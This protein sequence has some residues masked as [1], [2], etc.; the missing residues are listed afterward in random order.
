MTDSRMNRREPRVVRGLLRVAWYELRSNL[1]PPS[2]RRRLYRIGAAALGVA[3]WFGIFSA[4]RGGVSLLMKELP[5]VEGA[6]PQTVELL[7]AV[8]LFTLAYSG[9]VVTL[10]RVYL[11]DSLRLVGALPAEAGTLFWSYWVQVVAAAG[12]MPLAFGTA[13]LSGIGAALGVPAFWYL[14]LA[15]GFSLFVV[16][17]V[18]VSLLGTT[19]IATLLP[20]SR[21]RDMLLVMSLIGLVGLFVAIRSLRPERL[22]DQSGAKKLAEALVEL[23]APGAGWLP[24]S[25]LADSLTPVFSGGAVNLKALAVL[26][27]MTAVLVALS[28]FVFAAAFPIA[29]SQALSA[30]GQWLRGESWVSK[31][32]WVVTSPLPRSVAALTRKDILH[33]GRDAT[34]WSQLLLIVGLAVIYLFNMSALPLEDARQIGTSKAVLADWIAVINLMPA[35][36]VLAAVALRFVYAA[37]SLEGRAAWISLSAPSGVG[38]LV[39]AKIAVGFPILASLGVVLVTGTNAILGTSAGVA[40]LSVV[41]VLLLAFALTGLGAGLGVMQPNFRADHPTQV[42]TSVG[43]FVFMGVAVVFSL[44]F[45]GSCAPVAWYLHLSVV[46]GEPVAFLGLGAAACA[47]LAVVGAA[48]M[49]VVP[50]IFGMS[51]L[52]AQRLEP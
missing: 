9:V 4:M 46:G 39:A 11:A 17:S 47:G 18:T 40:T 8:L 10:G 32:V 20:A 38:A 1:W 48:A 21:A 2:T 43:G 41:A 25:H 36:F 5:G 50:L 22:G 3:L 42:V 6:L 19:A 27:A 29:R 16:A 44:L 12:W 15:L 33:L 28:R 23:E 51:R 24:S 7:T 37:I 49:T 13:V 31:L 35:S 30:R 26:F 52:D 45:V 34:Q 14:V